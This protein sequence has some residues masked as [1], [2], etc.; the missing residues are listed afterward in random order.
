MTNFSGSELVIPQAL[1][2]AVARDLRPVRPLAR[3]WQRA[4]IVLPLALVLLVAAPI[5][6]GLRGDA[7][8]VGLALTWGVSVFQLGLGMVLVGMALRE[9]V[10]GRALSTPSLV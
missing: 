8:R 6:F 7:G 9:A 5:V 2:D 1:R 4:A 3:P 10:P